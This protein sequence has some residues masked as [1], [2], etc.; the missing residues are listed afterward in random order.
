M[1]ARRYQR[2]STGPTSLSWFAILI[3][4]TVVGGVALTLIKKGM[5]LR[6]ERETHKVVERERALAGASQPFADLAREARPESSDGSTAPEGP[7]AGA[8]SAAKFSGSAWRKAL[9]LVEEADELYEDC[10]SEKRAGRMKS[11]NDKGRLARRKYDQALELTA[12]WEESLVEE[13]G[14]SDPGV[15]E[16]MRTRN[17]WFD[18]V[19]WLHKSVAR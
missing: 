18:R 7:F 19:R 13:H 15:R 8:K 6:E 16:I 11:M 4:M 2:P 3:G 14:D 1:S 5:S 17:Q 10:L 9:G 12:A